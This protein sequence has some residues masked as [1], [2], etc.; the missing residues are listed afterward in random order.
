MIKVIFCVNDDEITKFAS[1]CKLLM[2]IMYTVLYCVWKM[3]NLNYRATG[4]CQTPFMV[5]KEVEPFDDFLVLRLDFPALSWRLPCCCTVWPTIV[6]M[7]VQR[8]KGLPSSRQGL[9]CN[10]VLAIE[11]PKRFISRRMFR[12]SINN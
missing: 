10:L 4:M 3:W 5:G 11:S 6:C 1:S 9:F 2:Y 7:A 8:L 12:I